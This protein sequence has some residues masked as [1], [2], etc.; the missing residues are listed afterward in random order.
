MVYQSHFLYRLKIIFI[1]ILVKLKFVDFLL[2]KR[3]RDQFPSGWNNHMFWI[4]FKSGGRKVFFE[5]YC[6]LDRPQSYQ[7]KIIVS[8]EYQLTEQEIKGF[9]QNGFLPAFD[10]LS[11]QEAEAVRQHLV[12]LVQMESQ[13]YSYTRGDYKFAAQKD[14][15]NTNIQLLNETERYFYN[16]LNAWDRHLEDSILLNLFKSPAI[17][18]RCAQLLAPELVLWRTNFFDTPPF[19]NGST[20]HQSSTFFA[21]DMKE[22]ILQP[23]NVREL[24]VLTCWIALT[25][26]PKERSCMMFIPGSNREIYPTITATGDSDKAERIYGKYGERLDDEVNLKQVKYAEAKAGQCIIFCER[27]VHGSTKNITDRHRWSVVGRVVGKNTGIYSKR[28][29]KEGL[30]MKVYDVENIKLDCWKPCPIR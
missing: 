29:R 8:P 28:M 3:W 9:Y 2:P 17:T 30:N 15:K 5:Y 24:F 1:F 7:P 18:E 25:D 19:S 14:K 4:A 13:V 12:E 6:K 21:L 23:P 27:V 11:S 26:A 20:W 22:S 10:V 16:K